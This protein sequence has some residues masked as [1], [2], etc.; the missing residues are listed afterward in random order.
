MR[1]IEPADL[2][3]GGAGLVRAGD[4]PVDEVP[5]LSEV[6][7]AG[8]R[9]AFVGRDAEMALFRTALGDVA[10]CTVLYLHGTA[11]VGKSTVLRRCAAEAEAEGRVVLRMDR[12]DPAGI[13]AAVLAAQPL[14]PA[15][16]SAPV[17][18][19]DDFE[20]WRTAEVWLREDFF[21]G[22][23]LG[24]VVMLAG[25][26]APDV[27]WT[28]DPGWRDVVRIR[29]VVEFDT[30]ETG[31]WLDHEAVPAARR[32]LLCELSGGHPLL[33]STAAAA[34][35]AGHTDDEVRL[36]GA[37]AV[38][39]RLLDDLPTVE[40]R[41]AVELCAYAD[42]ATERMLHAGVPQADPVALLHWLLDQ[43]W[44][45]GD[46]VGV[47]LRPYLRRAMRTD[48]HWRDPARAYAVRDLVGRCGAA[49][50]LTRTAFDAAVRDALREYRRP[51]LLAGNPLAQSRMVL[52]A[53]E[54]TDPGQALRAV[55]RAAVDAMGEDPREGK[56]HRALTATYLGTAPTQDAA[57]QRLGLPFSTYRRHLT[58]GVRVLADL[59]WRRELT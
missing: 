36:T 55:L 37:R 22:L 40:H 21:P 39:R 53:A 33:L 24:T 42:P 41:R 45:V 51:D 23:P 16:A 27:A 10:R 5:R 59:L 7:R 9:R 17:L 38:I 12:C 35:A 49:R 46:D 4:T 48:L 25:R 26:G 52:A 54:H 8:R 2:R 34:V 43:P 44:T 20:Q 3:T 19:F 1:D 13:V 47:R 31:A 18:L 56:A 29:E 6:L 32:L 58:R 14:I 30:A 11:G 57:A 15:G 50:P 28:A